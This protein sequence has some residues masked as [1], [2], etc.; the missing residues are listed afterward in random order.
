MSNTQSETKMSINNPNYFKEYYQ[1]KTKV[2]SDFGLTNKICYCKRVY[3]ILF[4]KD[5]IEA[6]G[7]DYKVAARFYRD[8]QMM[9]SKYPEYYERAIN[10]QGGV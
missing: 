2:K 5:D 3:K 6:L 8:C 7:E 9:K 1:N 10:Q 4:N